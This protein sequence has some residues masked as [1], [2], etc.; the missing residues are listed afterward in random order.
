LCQNKTVGAGPVENGNLALCKLTN[1][2]AA[3]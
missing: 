2:L 3:T 1:S